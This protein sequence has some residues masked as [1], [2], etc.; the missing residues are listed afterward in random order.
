MFY[1]LHYKFMTS[2]SEEV[3]SNIFP[4]LRLPRTEEDISFNFIII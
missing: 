4:M 2:Q 1:W 3:I